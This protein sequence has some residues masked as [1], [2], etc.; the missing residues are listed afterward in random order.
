MQTLLTLS[1][2]NIANC[3]MTCSRRLSIQHPDKVLTKLYNPA[4]KFIINM[5]DA[6]RSSIE[7]SANLVK[8]YVN[9]SPP[10]PQARIKADVFFAKYRNSIYYAISCLHRRIQHQSI[11]I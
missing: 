11:V 6:K 5:S 1:H 4:R 2:H 7:E 3:F 10:K 9:N 8:V